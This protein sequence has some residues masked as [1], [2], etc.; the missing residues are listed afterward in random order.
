MPSLFQPLS[1][2]PVK[3]SLTEGTSIP[4]PPDSPPE[5]P[6][7]PTPTGGPLNSHPTTP[8]KANSTNGAVQPVENSQSSETRPTSAQ[9]SSPES[10]NG[11]RPRLIRR[12]FGLRP[13]KK[14]HSNQNGF[15]RSPSALGSYGP[16]LKPS[17]D[18]TFSSRPGSPYTTATG[19]TPTSPHSLTRK[20]SSGWFNS[21]KR[22]S[23]MFLV[24]RVDEGSLL[25]DPASVTAALEQQKP[26]TNGPPPPTLPEFRQFRS[27]NGELEA[28]HEMSAEDLFRNIGKEQ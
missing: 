22:R 10:P 9:P 18:L 19:E 25:D 6:R 17:D 12:F 15:V 11:K 13:S 16:Q 20:R 24:G 1:I 4:A 14:D 23:A 2:E 5:V 28:V 26:V 27:L 3:F 21:N 7:E 8:N